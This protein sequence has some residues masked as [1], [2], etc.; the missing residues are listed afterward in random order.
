MNIGLIGSGAIGKFLLNQI[1]GEKHNRL[2]IKSILVRNKEKYQE[3]ESKYDVKLYTDVDKFLD[4]GIDIVAEA[5][6]VETVREVIPEVVKKKDAI[7]ISIGALVDESLLAELNRLATEH[8]NEVYLPSG[9]IGGLD[10][11][12][13]TN[14][15]G[16]LTSVTLT[17]RKPAA[18]L[19]NE[20]ITEEK[21]MFDGK[22]ADA[23]KEFPKNVNVS[24]VLSLAGIG[25]EK[26]R[27]R[28]VADPSIDKNIHQIKLVGDFGE[29]TVSIT[30]N[31]LPENPKTSYLAA[32]S[33]LGT[34]D[35]VG[36]R[37][38]IGD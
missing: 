25:T 14:A 18:S 2:S 6:N 13:N 19:T 12:Q 10:L 35:R 15:L 29:A 1:N 33:I 22:A 30:N 16:S 8:N 21:V 38:R 4:S 3:L 32:M 9:G 36:K 7:L 28:L 27:M 17:T 37:I 5:A 26:T 31:P 34:L 20:E 23:I 24:I 11:V